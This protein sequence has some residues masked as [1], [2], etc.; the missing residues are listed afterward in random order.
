MDMCSL[1]ASL[2][3]IEHVCTHEKAHVPSSEKVSHKNEAG[4]KRPSTDATKQAH[5][6]ARFKK[7]C[8][9]CKKH[10]ARILRMLPKIAAS[11]RK[12]GR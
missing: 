7:S 9:L 2:D 5:K 11:T 10:G 4:A 12:T 8:K 1:Q 3:T 6:K